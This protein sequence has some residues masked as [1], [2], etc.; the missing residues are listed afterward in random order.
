MVHNDN[1][2][3]RVI[4]I[5]GIEHNGSTFLGL[6]LGNHPQIECVG[7]LSQLPRLG[8]AG[9]HMCA[10]GQPISQCTYWCDVRETWQRMT[11]E[12]IEVILA[13]ERSFDR[14]GSLPRVLLEN[15]IRTPAFSRYSY[16][17]R[18][19]FEA[20]QQVSGKSIIVDTSKR[21]SRALALSMIEGIDLR[22]IHL[23][24]DARGVAYSS[25]KPQR[26]IQKTP[27]QSAARWR[28]INGSLGIVRQMMKEE[29]SIVVRY[30]DFIADPQRELERIGHF[31]GVDLSLI[32]D[33]LFSGRPFVSNHI[34]I[35]NGF[36]QGKQEVVLHRKIDWPKKMSQKEQQLVWRISA[37]GMRKFGYQED[38]DEFQLPE[39]Y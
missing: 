16:H 3:L 22:L 24:R 11:G 14:N 18:S 33:G 36:L 32:G 21:T 4:Y 20:I 2:Q 1:H 12:E 15:Y 9:D 13:E 28:T 31:S 26:A 35:G 25:A 19:L 29:K 39:G 8:W 34:G 27:R 17:T 5:G 30:E 7:E 10:C 38:P 23:V 37:G 6:A